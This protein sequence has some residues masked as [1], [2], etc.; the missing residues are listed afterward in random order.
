VN[1]VALALLYAPDEGAHQPGAFGRV[2]L[3]QQ[4][5]GTITRQSNSHSGT[6]DLKA[7]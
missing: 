7:C 3:K 5:R 4:M 1:Q 6:V 2:G